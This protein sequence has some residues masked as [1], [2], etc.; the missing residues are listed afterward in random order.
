VSEVIGIKNDFR[1]HLKGKVG[2]GGLSRHLMHLNLIVA[3]GR[4][5]GVPHATFDAEH[6]WDQLKFVRMDRKAKRL[7]LALRRSGVRPSEVS[8]EHL[9]GWSAGCKRRG[10]TGE[11]IKASISQ[12]KLT[13]RTSNLESEFPNLDVE[14]KTAP[15][16][17]V[18]LKDMLPHPRKQ[19]EEIL[20]RLEQLDASGV[21]WKCKST[22]DDFSAKVRLL[23]GYAVENAEDLGIMDGEITD[24][25]QIFNEKV[26]RNCARWGA[27]DKGWNRDTVRMFLHRLHSVFKI[28]SPYS[29][30]NWE[31]MLDLITEFPPEPESKKEERQARRAFDYDYDTVATIPK[32]ICEERLVAKNLGVRERERRIMCEFLMLFLVT[33]PWP[34]QCL[35]SCTVFSDSANLYMKDGQ[36]YF[37]FGA[38]EVSFRRAGKGPLAQRLVP[39]LE[40]YLKYRGDE[41]GPLFR[42]KRGLAFT[43]S[44]L[45]AL[46]EDLTEAYVDA[47]VPGSDFRDI[48][49]YWW[50][51]NHTL[52]EGYFSLAR[53]LWISDHACRMRYDKDYRRAYRAK[54]PEG[55]RRRRKKALA[56]QL[57]AAA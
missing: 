11:A 40:L 17:C 39:L 35:A 31:W 15:Q 18:A 3:S 44:R 32:Q 22:R 10:L 45:S 43:S 25:D 29:L 13:I 14:S 56:P 54:H 5:M 47:R 7:V 38:L 37:R 30:H 36:W 57:P 4:A 26:I 55:A 53:I 27:I 12:F 34:V 33:C 9:D 16:V 41:P 46:I 28:L 49:G 21:I 19:L 2:K 8:Q 20:Q 48:F 42:T 52:P 1:Q 6:E 50:L 51:L 24:L 23:Y